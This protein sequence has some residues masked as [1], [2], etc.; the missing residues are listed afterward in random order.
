MVTIRRAKIPHGYTYLA[1]LFFVALLGVVSATAGVLWSTAQQ[2][3]LETELLFVGS[4]YRAAIE[5]YYRSS[6]GTVRRYPL[7]LADLIDDSRQL[8]VRRHLRRLY[9]DP[10]TGQSEWGLIRAP[11]GGIMGVHSLSSQTPMKLAN[12]PLA[13][14]AFEDSRSYQGWRFMVVQNNAP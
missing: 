10:V 1:V 11:D 2:R 12:F 13:Y 5:S 8:G 9:R 6:P 7:A 14:A 3:E 4:Q